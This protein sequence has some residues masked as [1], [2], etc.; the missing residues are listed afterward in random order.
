MKNK[1]KLLVICIL[2]VMAVLSFVACDS[3]R[4]SGMMPSNPVVGAWSIEDTRYDDGKE[5]N[6][7]GIVEC[8]S[9]M[10]VSFTTVINGT[11]ASVKQGIYQIQGNEITA[12]FDGGK[13]WEN[14]LEFYVQG[15]NLFI[16][17]GENE[18]T[19]YKRVQ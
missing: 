5:I 19:R 17:S 18:F 10:K 11:V 14:Y 9:D 1:A 6:M 7:I 2:S 4:G 3:G 12:S 8:T 13:T 15:E 16:A